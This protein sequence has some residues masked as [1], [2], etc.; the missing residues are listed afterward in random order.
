VSSAVAETN[1]QVPAPNARPKTGQGGQS[2]SGDAFSGMVDD[3]L[4][5]TDTGE[6]SPTERSQRSAR[7]EG[8]EQQPPRTGVAFVSSL[9]S[10]SARRV[11][12]AA[13]SAE[14]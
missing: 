4:A 1:S 11:S 5:A 7:N 3:N 12:F 13:C 9:G 14:V 10:A 8:T 6:T 2:S